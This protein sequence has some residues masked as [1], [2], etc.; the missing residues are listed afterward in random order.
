MIPTN[1]ESRRHAGR[2]QILL[3]RING[4]SAWQDSIDARHTV[5]NHQDEWSFTP[6]PA[7]VQK[8]AQRDIPL[9]PENARR[10]EVGFQPVYN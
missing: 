4:E 6:W 3:H 10:G 7:D 1:S 2:T 5:R 8:K 9:N